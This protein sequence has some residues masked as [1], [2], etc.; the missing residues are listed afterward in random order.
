MAE[1]LLRQLLARRGLKGKVTSAGIAAVPGAPAA[2]QA[3]QV[4]REQGLDLTEHEATLLTPDLIREADLILTMTS[5]HKDAIREMAPGAI[6][7]TFS[8]PEFVGEAGDVH[9][10][11]G[12]GVDVY[13]ETAVRLQRLLERAL[14]KLEFPGQG[15]G[16]GV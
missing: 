4:M 14:E 5:S 16:D 12:Q 11:V 8:L 15:N 7:K 3:V 1:A 13:R 9:D 6:E 10:P 2:E